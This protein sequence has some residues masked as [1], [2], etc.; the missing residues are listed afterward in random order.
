MSST[1]PQTLRNTVPREH[2]P[3]VSQDRNGASEGRGTIKLIARGPDRES[4]DSRSPAHLATWFC[5]WSNHFALGSLRNIQKE[6]AQTGQ[7]FACIWGDALN[8]TD[9]TRYPSYALPCLLPEVLGLDGTADPVNT[10]MNGNGPLPARR[11]VRVQAL[12]LGHA[13][14]LTLRR[15]PLC[16][17]QRPLPARGRSA[18]PSAG[19]STALHPQAQ[20]LSLL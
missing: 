20:A 11:P 12:G 18:G 3:R 13:P 14:R 17:P 1:T 6:F 9:V 4:G 7:V 16:R 2:A 8:T 10:P 5:L 19:H 15:R